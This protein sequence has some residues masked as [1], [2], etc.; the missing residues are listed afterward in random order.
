MRVSDQNFIAKA[1]LT[2]A[3]WRAHH[4][5]PHVAVR[6]NIE[7]FQA[8]ARAGYRFDNPGNLVL[9][10]YTKAAQEKMRA[11]GQH[12]PIHSSG[13]GDWNDARLEQVQRISERVETERLLGSEET[14]DE[15]ARNLLKDLEQ[16]LRSEVLFAER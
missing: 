4:L 9:L 12:R 15:L 16:E 11:A 14:A 2:E 13:H 3:D 8:A 6:R 10:P 7:L 5:I 1:G